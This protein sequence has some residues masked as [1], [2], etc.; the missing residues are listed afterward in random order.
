MPLVKGKLN[1]LQSFCMFVH[2]SSCYLSNTLLKL[3][4]KYPELVKTILDIWYGLRYILLSKVREDSG[5][6]NAYMRILL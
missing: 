4:E 3:F 6:A 5:F 1:P 2:D